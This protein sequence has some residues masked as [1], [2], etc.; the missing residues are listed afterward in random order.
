MVLAAVRPSAALKA[1]S[2][3]IVS[4]RDRE[5]RGQSESRVPRV[6]SLFGDYTKSE[7]IK[8][9]M[10]PNLDGLGTLS[11]THSDT[12]LETTPKVNQIRYG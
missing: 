8:V 3:H 1:D 4:D 2:V 6:E 12:L 11:A 10:S 7:L 5:V 9:W